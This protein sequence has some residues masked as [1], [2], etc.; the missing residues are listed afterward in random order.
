MHTQAQLESETKRTSERMDKDNTTGRRSVPLLHLVRQLLRNEA[1][2]TLSRLGEGAGGHPT[3]RGVSPNL[4]LLLKFQRL[5]FINLYKLQD[6]GKL[7]QIV[8]KMH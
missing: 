5:L 6:E 7:A 4:R 3:P 8:T 2:Q 1:S